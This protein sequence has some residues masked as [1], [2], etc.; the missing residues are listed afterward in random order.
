M[1]DGIQ[2]NDI[3]T[4][5]DLGR[6]L[7]LRAFAIVPQ[8]RTVADGSEEKKTAIAVLKR[9]A[10]RAADIGTGVVESRSRN[11]SSIKTRDVGR[12]LQ[13]EDLA[14][15]RLIFGIPEPTRPG[16]LGSFPADRPISA[17]WPER[18]A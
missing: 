16:P 14:D 1:A 2:H 12:A 17:L 6:V 9:V 4:D 8:L 13:T 11:G 15:L 3:T 7:L 5:E 18:T 10:K